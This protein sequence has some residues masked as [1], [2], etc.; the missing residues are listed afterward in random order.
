MTISICMIWPASSICAWPTDVA[1]ILN[2]YGLVPELRQGRVGQGRAG[3]IGCCWLSM[4][5][6]LG[7]QE[8]SARRGEGVQAACRILTPIPMLFPHTA[9][10]CP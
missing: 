5:G 6:G 1:F 9:P 2:R 7:A 4:Y 3:V 8:C 10:Y